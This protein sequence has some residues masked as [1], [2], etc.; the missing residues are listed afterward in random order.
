MVEVKGKSKE[1]AQKSSVVISENKQVKWYSED[2]LSNAIIEAY[3]NFETT[4]RNQLFQN[5]KEKMDVAKEVC[6][7]IYYALNESK[8][9]Q[10][11]K[12][13]LRP[14][15]LISFEAIIVIPE[16]IFL[17]DA[18]KSAYEIAFGV[19]EGYQKPDFNFD[20]NFMPATKHI[21]HS[22]LVADGFNLSFR[23]KS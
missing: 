16:K 18:F 13:F 17:S 15:S 20:F 22:A 12:V 1:V 19:V 6:E 8:N 10:C 9:L 5:L 4:F 14:N 23:L 2:E 21:N 3:K 7:K 11:Q